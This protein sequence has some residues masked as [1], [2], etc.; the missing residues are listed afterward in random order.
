MSFEFTESFT[1][2]FPEIK[3]KD[4][5]FSE[6]FNDGKGLIIEVAAIHER[7]NWKL[8]QLFCNRT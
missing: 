2:E 7:T 4:F 6:S 8:Q 3:E 1:V 5:N